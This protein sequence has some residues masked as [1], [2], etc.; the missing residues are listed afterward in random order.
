MSR[1]STAFPGASWACV[2]L[3]NL[4]SPKYRGIAPVRIER[5][6]PRGHVGTGLVRAAT[7]EHGRAT[8]TG[9]SDGVDPRAERRRGPFVERPCIEVWKPVNN[10]LFRPFRLRH[11]NEFA[12]AHAKP[13]HETLRR[14]AMQAQASS[15]TPPPNA[16]MATDRRWRLPRDAGDLDGIDRRDIPSVHALAVAVTI[17]EATAVAV[18]TDPLASAVGGRVTL[19]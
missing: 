9:V 13:W 8:D 16:G 2:C 4:L 17:P 15:T 10:V 1:S 7:Q 11:T 19:G 3:S 18:L 6:F 12:A 5:V 14:G